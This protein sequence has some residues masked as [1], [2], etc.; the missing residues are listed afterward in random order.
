MLNAGA[1]LL[2]GAAIVVGNGV[3]GGVVAY[4]VAFVFFLAPYAILAQP[5]HTA[6]LP[7]LSNEGASGDLD[8]FAHSSVWALD[9][10]AALVVPV[11]AALVAFALP[12]MSIV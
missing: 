8:A 7:D 3:A 2:L 4:Q 9:R 12:M 11:S 10:M 1:A 6:I 5:I